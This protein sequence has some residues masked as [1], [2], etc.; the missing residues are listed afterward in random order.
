M[1]N[2][3][4]NNNNDDEIKIFDGL[5]P[6]DMRQICYRMLSRS[7][8][9]FDGGGSHSRFWHMNDLEDDWFFKESVFDYV[10]RCLLI[11]NNPLQDG[12]IEV[13]RIYAN[14][15]TATQS[16]VV[17]QDDNTTP[18][19]WTFLYYSTPNWKQEYAGN[20]QFFDGKPG[21]LIKTVQY[22]SNRAVLFPSSMYHMAEAPCRQYHGL[23]TTIAYKMN[24]QQQQPK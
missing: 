24:I 19:A 12:D 3:I 4:N 15:Q 5:L 22:V 10:K 14:G 17:H 20:T 21:A 23:R 6:E 2:S 18:N 7:K 16:G 8:W 1:S 13:K 11:C 9:S